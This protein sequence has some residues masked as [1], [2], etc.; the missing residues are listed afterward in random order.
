MS[1]Q[2]KAILIRC[3]ANDFQDALNLFQALSDLSA[4]VYFVYVGEVLP[5]GVPPHI[6]RRIILINVDF[7]KRTGLYTP[8]LD[9]AALTWQCGD[10]ALYAAYER[11]QAEYFWIIEPDVYASP[12]IAANL[13]SAPLQ[14]AIYAPLLRSEGEGWYFYDGTRKYFTEVWTCIFCLLAIRRDV[15]PELRQRRADILAAWSDT[16]ERAQLLPN[17]EA[18]VCSFLHAHGHACA[19]LNSLGRFYTKRSIRFSMPVSRKSLELRRDAQRLIHHPVC[20]GAFFEYKFRQRFADFGA[21]YTTVHDYF[22][23]REL[24][25]IAP[26]VDQMTVVGY[27]LFVQPRATWRNLN[28]RT[29]NLV[30]AAPGF[31]LHHLGRV[32]RRVLKRLPDSLVKRLPYP[33]G[34]RPA[35]AQEA[36]ENPDLLAN[37][38]SR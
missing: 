38:R 33:I 4:P 35:A 36:S 26:L 17:D 2:R 29:H 15:L 31:L 32:K 9:L 12:E 13:F 23:E 22:V 3:C 30:K 11:V 37:H 10:L 7:L 18:F 27:L 28:W 16:D 8:R 1:E 20:A 19:D 34:P 5:N 14:A 25:P 24:L 6:A 21:S